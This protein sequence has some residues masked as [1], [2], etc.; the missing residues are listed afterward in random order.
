[1]TKHHH[2]DLQKDQKKP[3]EEKKRELLEDDSDIIE[4]SDIAIGTT[5]EDDIIVELT[6]EVIDEAMIGISG[7]TRDSFKEG[8]EYLDLSRGDKDVFTGARQSKRD[9]VE[10]DKSADDDS[11]TAEEMESH[12]TRELDDFFSSEEDSPESVEKSIQPLV[13]QI[14]TEVQKVDL[15][16]SH[17]D[18]LEAIE[19]AV[20]KIYGDRI[21]QLLEDAIEKIVRNE[22][23]RIKDMLAGKIP[24]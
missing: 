17:S 1:M 16:I 19:A 21:N 8:E 4:L 2:S 13:T 6:E 3:S 11:M 18:L 5:P 10:T 23:K 7:A 9:I 15:T 12:I 24:K 14:K 22:I 20:K